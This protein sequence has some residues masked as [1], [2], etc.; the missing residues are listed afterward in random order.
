MK[1]LKKASL[2]ASIA[3]VS[4]AANAELV[5]MDES[6]LA[7][8]TGQAGI[9]IDINLGSDVDAISIGSITWT[10]TAD[11]T[12]PDDISGGG[13]SLTTVTLGSANNTPVVLTNSIDVNAD[14][15]IVIQT[16]AVNN[17]RLGIAS[18][19]TV[20]LNSANLARNVSLDMNLTG[21]TITIGATADNDG[22]GNDDTLIT[23]RGGSVEITDG[24]AD[25]L[26]GAI[27]LSGIKAYGLDASGNPSGGL[28]TDADILFNNNG[29][30]V[31]NLNL[32]G[33]I[34][35][36]DVALGGSSIGSVAISNIEMSAS[37][38]ISGH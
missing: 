11:A 19:D 28:S 21:S 12:N 24:S 27:G 2:A 1:F 4:F 33:T 16:G 26:N 13:V 25:L 8:A 14:G 31:S 32:A 34:E 29:I 35:L 7:A 9:D 18:V 30:T 22:D 10:D 17:L 6:A 23:T 5:A 3:A 36:G 15:E 38:T 20:G 37:L